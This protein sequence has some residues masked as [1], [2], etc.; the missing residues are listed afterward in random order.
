M[1]GKRTATLLIAICALALAAGG[2]W[3]QETK[4]KRPSGAIG[5]LTAIDA[6]KGRLTIKTTQGA[7]A[8]ATVTPE[9]EYLLTE[10]G[11]KSLEG[12]EQISLADIKVGDRVWARGEPD[13]SGVIAARQVIVMSAEAIAERNR[14]DARDW[15]TRGLIGEVRAVDPATNDLTVQ[16][17]RGD[18]VVV[19]IGSGTTVRRLRAG[20]TDLSHA[21]PIA[22]GD[23]K[24]GNQVAVRGNRSAD[25]SRLTAE[26]VLTGT[27][28]RPVRG[29]VLS[30]DAAKS[31]LQI[32]ERDGR[33]VELTLGPGAL[34][35]KLVPQMPPAGAGGPGARPGGAPPAGQ[36]PP[37]GDQAQARPG[38][39]PAQ[40]DGAAPERRGPRGFAFALG[41]Q[42]ELERRTT[43]I[44]LSN[45]A[46]GDVVFA[47][48]EPGATD[49]AARVK[50]LVKFELPADRTP[51]GPGMQGP[52]M[53][54]Q[55]P[56]GGDDLPF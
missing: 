9:T 54:Q 56:G 42:R 32:A 53:P 13:S 19:G 10:P 5:N 16:T 35:R 33:T 6:T 37:Q 22:A 17:Y 49:T 11:K 50:V 26:T 41:D 43:P 40:G 46:P 8:T 36:R 24:A 7:E 1:I 23:I 25:G 20:A 38:G 55:D 4:P 39:P 18:T 52:G 30:V 45:I 15:Q 29:R 14:R 28:P 51:R 12:A 47:V 48:V 27:F 34:V 44:E 2:A 31:T 3:A 21:D